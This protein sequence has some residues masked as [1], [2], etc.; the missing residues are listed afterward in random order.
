MNAPQA[1]PPR[2]K[3]EFSGDQHKRMNVALIDIGNATAH[4]LLL[5]LVT[6]D[7]C[8]YRFQSYE[9]IAKHMRL[10]VSTVKRA[11]RYLRHVS[12]VI[13]WKTGRG[14]AGYAGTP[15]ANAYR[16]NYTALAA[17]RDA[18]RPQEDHPA[19]EREI[20]WQANAHAMG[21]D[22]DNAQ[23]VEGHP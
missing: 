15:K 1:I 2:W 18:Q 4:H 22:S 13:D 16:I 20:D 9:N 17:L 23:V 19:E 8:R 12:H 11:A 6:C 21:F 14:G 5:Y 7:E 3:R 10:S